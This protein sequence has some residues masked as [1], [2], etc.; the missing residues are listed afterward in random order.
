[1]S[2]PHRYLPTIEAIPIHRG[3][4][5]GTRC[6]ESS[7]INRALHYDAHDVITPHALCKQ[8]QIFMTI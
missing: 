4:N 6:E 2:G 1:M 8:H 3:S 5:S 7:V